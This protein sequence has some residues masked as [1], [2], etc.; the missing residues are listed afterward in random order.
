[1]GDKVKTVVKY[2]LKKKGGYDAGI[3][4]LPDRL[5]NY[6]DIIMKK[7]FNEALF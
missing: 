2:Y 4:K 7:M 6:F 3:Q 5:N 1:M